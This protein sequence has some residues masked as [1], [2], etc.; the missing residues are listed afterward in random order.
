MDLTDNLTR[1]TAQGGDG[2]RTRLPGLQPQV[3]GTPLTH[4]APTSRSLSR[5]ELTFHSL[6]R[7]LFY[8]HQ[9]RRLQGGFALE[10]ATVAFATVA[11]PADLISSALPCSAMFCHF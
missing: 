5:L 2:G 3:H 9:T 4:R 7:S 1:M 8:N 10:T 11:A 6:M